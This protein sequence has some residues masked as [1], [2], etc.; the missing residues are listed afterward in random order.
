MAPAEGS[1]WTGHSL[2]RLV[3][4]DSQSG[5]GHYPEEPTSLLPDKKRSGDCGLGQAEP[6]KYRVYRAGDE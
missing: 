5:T 4:P 1:A 3:V 6:E 2:G